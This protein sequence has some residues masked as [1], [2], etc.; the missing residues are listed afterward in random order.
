MDG[1]A[2][3]LLAHALL[4]YAYLPDT[5]GQETSGAI[6]AD[7]F[8]GQRPG[9]YPPAV[10]AGILHHRSVDAF[11]DSHPRFI[12]SRDVLAPKAPPHAAS[13]LVDL[14]WDN[15]L[16][17]DWEEYGRPLCGFDLPSFARSVYG[18]LERSAKHRSPLF[19]R[20]APWI[21]SMDW[22]S[23]YASQEGIDRALQGL[24][25]RLPHGAPLAGCGRLL[26]LHRFS[27]ERDFRAFWPEVAEHARKAA[28]SLGNVT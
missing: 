8:S 23:A 22:L 1:N 3:N 26:P 12:S 17:T 21:I 25:A 28:E 20:V 9:D 13:I 18:R 7:Y 6:M 14:F 4:A 15:I 27:L 19:A 16:G 24:S 11:T 2:M 5:D 10:A